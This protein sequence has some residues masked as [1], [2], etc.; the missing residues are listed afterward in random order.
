MYN[1][2]IWPENIKPVNGALTLQLP[3]EN[4]EVGDSSTVYKLIP[5]TEHDLDKQKISYSRVGFA[6][7]R[8]MGMSIGLMVF[9][10]L[11][12]AFGAVLFVYGPSAMVDYVTAFTGGLFFLLTAAVGITSSAKL[13]DCPIAGTMV[14][15]VLGAMSGA[16][17]ISTGGYVMAFELLGTLTAVSPTISLAMHAME[18][19]CGLVGMCLCLG[20][21]GTSCKAICCGERHFTVTVIPGRKQTPKVQI[22]PVPM[23]YPMSS[24]MPGSVEMSY[25]SRHSPELVKEPITQPVGESLQHRKLDGESLPPARLVQDNAQQQA[26]LKRWKTSKG[27]LKTVNVL[28]GKN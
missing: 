8:V 28:Y 6:H 17:M 27:L 7:F 21:S 1:S 4:G 23:G 18:I 14:L 26:N 25:N 2:T 20:L 13:K 3:D 5:V 19:V 22:L 11:S 10:L 12:F 15:S 9:G 16:A 24:Y